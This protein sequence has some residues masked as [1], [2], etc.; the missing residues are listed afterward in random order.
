VERSIGGAEES[1]HEKEGEGIS[2]G[3]ERRN[4]VEKWSETESEG[5]RAIRGE[6]WGVEEGNNNEE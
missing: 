2:N 4:I 6:R 3:R 5:E 1:Y